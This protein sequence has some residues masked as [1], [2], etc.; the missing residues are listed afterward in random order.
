MT[1]SS[2]VTW[3]VR[4]NQTVFH[5]CICHVYTSDIWIF[6]AFFCHKPINTCY[7]A[8]LRSLFTSSLITILWV[9]LFQ[10]INLCQRSSLLIWKAT[11]S[12]VKMAVWL[13]RSARNNTSCG[14]FRPDFEAF[15]HRT[16]QHFW[17]NWKVRTFYISC[18]QNCPELMSNS[19]WKLRKC[20][21]C[22]ERNDFL[23]RSSH[24]QII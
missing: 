12:G 8:D 15:T 20:Q 19:V 7:E 22:S 1:W 10:R 9:W 21:L 6:M 2:D 23:L 16:P 17:E 14:H 24:A 4:T 3:A 18:R 13:S 11:E 5:S